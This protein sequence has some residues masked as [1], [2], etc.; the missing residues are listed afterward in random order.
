MRYI[1]LAL[2]I[3]ACQP[4]DIVENVSRET[5]APTK[6]PVKE[7]VMPPEEHIEQPAYSLCSLLDS[8]HHQMIY[9]DFDLYEWVLG[10]QFYKTIGREF[11]TL[12]EAIDQVVDAAENDGLSYEMGLT[13][14]NIRGDYYESRFQMPESADI[15]VFVDAVTCLVDGEGPFACSDE[16]T[17]VVT[18]KEPLSCD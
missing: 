18:T 6:D 17:V 3:T 2:A 16:E 10:E 8:R 9:F 14:T 13:D 12:E 5:K 1:I 15:R 4:Q 11:V 7:R